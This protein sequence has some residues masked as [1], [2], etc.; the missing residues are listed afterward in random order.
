M[1]YGHRKP[2]MPKSSGSSSPKSKCKSQTCPKVSLC[3]P[4]QLWRLK[5]LQS[6]FILPPPNMFLLPRKGR[7]RGKSS[8]FFEILFLFFLKVLKIIVDLQ[9]SV[10]FR[11][12]AKWYKYA[13]FLTLSSIMFH[14]KWL[15][16]P[17]CYTARSHCLSTP[18][19]NF[20]LLFKVI[21]LSILLPNYTGLYH[22]SSG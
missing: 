7:E 17:L 19:W 13:L 21:S 12:I 10:N 6:Y 3:P 4:S 22:C 5:A 20:K 9:C 18:N 8:S 2:H 15:D 14:H 16:T 11:S 1:S